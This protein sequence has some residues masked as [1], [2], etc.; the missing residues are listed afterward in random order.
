VA[1]VVGSVTNSESPWFFGKYGWV[2]R[3]VRAFQKPIVCP[4]AQGLWKVEG[5]FLEQL[6]AELNG[7]TL[8]TVEDDPRQTVFDFG[9]QGG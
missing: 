9:E 2:L 1:R 8:D 7:Q 5:Q 6:I 4:G 3:D